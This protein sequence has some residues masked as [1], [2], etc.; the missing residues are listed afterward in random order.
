MV[1]ILNSKDAPQVLDQLKDWMMLEWGEPISFEAKH[2]QILIPAPLVALNKQKQLIG[3]LAF[4]TAP[5][6]QTDEVGVW[7]NALLVAPDYRRKGI[8]SR[9]IKSAVAEAALKYVSQLYV[10]TEFAEL[11]ISNGWTLLESEDGNAVLTRR[12]KLVA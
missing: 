6:P 2:P 1:S 4:T 7:I 5:V 11:Y 12:T 8:A 9:L 10:Y 3:G